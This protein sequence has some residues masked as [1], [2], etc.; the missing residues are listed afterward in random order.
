MVS[1]APVLR[2]AWENCSARNNHDFFS[3]PFTLF[4][5]HFVSQFHS[6]DRFPS[7]TVNYTRYSFIHPWRCN[8]TIANPLTRCN[9]AGSSSAAI[10]DN[11]ESCIVTEAPNYVFQ[12]ERISIRQ[13]FIMSIQRF[14]PK[15]L[16]SSKSWRF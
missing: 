2:R 9:F 7:I 5:T 3:H 10:N 8:Q 1:N 13:H 12:L 11:G 6:T 16:A 14:Y 4:Q 15:L